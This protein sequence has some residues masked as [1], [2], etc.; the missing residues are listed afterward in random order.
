MTYEMWL[1]HDKDKFRL[2][3]LPDELNIG[4]GS[5][6]QTYSVAKLGEVNIIQDPVLKTFTFSS[7]LPA[8]YGPYCEYKKVPKP[9]DVI[10]KWEK[11][12]RTGNPSRFIFTGFVNMAV[13]IEDLS[14]YERGG[15]VGTIHYT[16]TLKEYKTITVRKV[17]HKASPRPSPPPPPKKAAAKTKTHTVKSG[18]TLWAL[19]V[20]YY[21]NGTQWKKIW[22][23]NKKLLT[24]RDK[25]N[26]KQPGH[27]IYP[28]QK[29]TIP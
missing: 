22:E 10:K 27:W 12:K 3:V 17:T 29:L 26:L 28:G 4:D 5:M 21:K 15:E 1:T 19:A 2:P 16:L 20:K 8:K 7:F 11:W 13:T 6:N 24:D 18:D 25:R 9:W 14:Y 23:K